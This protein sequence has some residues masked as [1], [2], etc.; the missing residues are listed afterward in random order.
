[1]S[2]ETLLCWVHRGPEDFCVGLGA[3]LA[4]LFCGSTRARQAWQAEAR[5]GHAA[6]VLFAAVA[7]G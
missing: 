2:R 4:I 6:L 1:M 5:H 7:S 3:T